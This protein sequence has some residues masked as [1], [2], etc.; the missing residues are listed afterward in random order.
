M[1][2]KKILHN[3]VTDSRK[4]DVLEL[5]GQV[6]DILTSLPR[7]YEYKLH[8]L[9]NAFNSEVVLLIVKKEV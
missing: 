6:V 2:I 1:S 7:G 4:K 9:S 5:E 3:D 8:R